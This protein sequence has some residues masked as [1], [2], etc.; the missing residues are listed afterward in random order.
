MKD[1]VIQPREGHKGRSFQASCVAFVTANTLFTEAQ[2]AS[3]I[4]PVWAMF[5]STE[6]ELRPFAANLRLGR[7][8][9]KEGQSRR[10]GDGERLEFLKSVGYLMSWQRESE[11]SL[12]TLYHPELFRL[13]PGLVDP[14]GISFVLLVPSDWS[15][16]QRVDV[17]SN[18]RH[19]QALYPK[20]DASYLA[21]LVP[22]AYLFAAYLDRRTRCPLVADGKFYMQLL[23]AALDT[24]LA[25][26]PGNNARYHSHRDDW[27]HNNRHHFDLEI[28]GDSY[29][30]ESL[31][32]IGIKHAVSFHASHATFEAF[33]AEQV[34]SFF[35][36]VRGNIRPVAEQID[37]RRFYATA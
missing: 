10:G 9:E 30:R 34:T 14:N 8:A 18:V 1:Y 13:D 35:G 22:T 4:R 21:S 28:G 29:S 3:T 5:A 26:L 2:G 17:A 33:V 16:A 19:V 6:A 15:D 36:S 37:L 12:V 27:G 23:L 11:G 32:T 31:E 24:G 25:S 7:K 20:L